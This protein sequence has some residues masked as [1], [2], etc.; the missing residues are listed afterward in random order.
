MKI[1]NKYKVYQNKMSD[2]KSLNEEIINAHNKHYETSKTGLV[3]LDESPNGNIIYHLY[4]DGSITY[5]KGGWAYQQRSEF[6]YLYPL[7][8]YKILCNEFPKKTKDE[9]TTYAI[10]T[11]EECITFRKK[12]D[13]MITNHLNQKP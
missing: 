8:N 12:M 5:Q 11:R 7:S 6:V 10:L 2:I 4:S 9:T 3:L 13:E 1:K